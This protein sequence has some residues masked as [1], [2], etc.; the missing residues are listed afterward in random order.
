[1]SNRWFDL[2]QEV[3]KSK[4][5]QQ[6]SLSEVH[7]Y[8][9]SGL[10]NCSILGLAQELEEIR[11]RSRQKN[12]RAMALE[13]ESL[14]L[15]DPDEKTRGR[16]NSAPLP[17]T[18]PNP[19]PSNLPPSTVST[20]TVNSPTTNTPAIAPITTRQRSNSAPEVL[21]SGGA[22]FKGLGFRYGFKREYPPNPVTTCPL[23]ADHPGHHSTQFIRVN[24]IQVEPFVLRFVQDPLT[25]YLDLRER[26]RKAKNGN[27][28]Y[29]ELIEV[30][31][32]IRR[33]I[34]A[35]KQGIHCGAPDQPNQGEFRCQVHP[36][37]SD[38]LKQEIL[39]P[40]FGNLSVLD[41]ILE[42]IK[43][44][45]GASY[46]Y[47]DSL[48]LIA[49]FMK[50]VDYIT[51]RAKTEPEAKA[52]I[53]TGQTLSYEGS[54]QYSLIRQS[55]KAKFNSEFGCAFPVYK[56]NVTLR[57]IY[58]YAPDYWPH[59]GYTPDRLELILADPDIILLPSYNPLDAEF[60]TKIRQVPMFLVGLINL[61]FLKA[62]RDYQSPL[63]FFD[64]D[65]FHVYGVPSSKP[66]LFHTMKYRVEE[67][68][69][70]EQEQG[71]S[72]SS[73]TMIYRIW[74]QNTRILRGLIDQ[75]KNKDLVE[76][77]NI[78]LFTV[79]HEPLTN[80]SGVPL[81]G[82]NN[83]PALVDKYAIANRLKDGPNGLLLA[84]RPRI[85]KGEFGTIS[86]GVQNQLD[87]AAQWILNQVNLLGD[88]PGKGQ[89]RYTKDRKFP[90]S[91]ANAWGDP[92]T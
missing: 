40:A 43:K 39:Q 91:A 20:T 82:V 79:L 22:L 85:L 36:G 41:Q 80:P 30:F 68:Q 5:E 90:N 55:R 9:T 28:N 33:H 29:P 62:D 16:S 18:Q 23:A 92:L 42:D 69:R 51:Y 6:R 37:V 67:I 15:G 49:K 27:F 71:K 26:A 19:V 45:D 2:E 4:R 44:L 11:G 54:S 52:L 88:D 47:K 21:I 66:Q 57:E 34:N 63:Q 76:A 12:T 53:P 78:V 31:L 75:V 61:E 77:I 84:L 50:L 8:D 87:A 74:D 1:M 56:P 46:P 73:P 13:L 58:S 7:D 70:L 25:M 38:Q 65:C 17:R 59:G 32:N 81:K 3:L 10:R 64:H 14:Q 48:R 60:F 89:G 72:P 86:A 35:I 83:L 24:Q